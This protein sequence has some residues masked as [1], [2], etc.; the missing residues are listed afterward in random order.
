MLTP[1]YQGLGNHDFWN[2]DRDRDPY[3]LSNC[4]PLAKATYQQAQPKIKEMQQKI[5]EAKRPHVIV[6]QVAPAVA[7]ASG[8]G[9]A[10][11]LAK[12]ADMHQRGL[13]DDDEFK[14]AKQAAI[15]KFS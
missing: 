9:L 12:F 1:S 2:K 3:K 14:A 8:G 10:D 13:L 4:L 5:L 15:A 11:E 6:Q 7:T